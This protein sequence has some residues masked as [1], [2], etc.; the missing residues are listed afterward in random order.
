MDRALSEITIATLCMP[1]IAVSASGCVDEDDQKVR[2]VE[3]H[4]AV[5][6]DGTH[7]APSIVGALGR[8]VG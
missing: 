5:V 2:E 3:Y 6:V 1:S 4:E 7:A 8:R